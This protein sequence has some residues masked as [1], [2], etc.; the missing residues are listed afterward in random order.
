M[1]A[2]A[3]DLQQRLARAFAS[4]CTDLESERPVLHLAPGSGG[5]V[6]V[7]LEPERRLGDLDKELL[8]LFGSHLCLAFDNVSLCDRLQDANTRLEERVIQRTAELQRA[9]QRLAAQR[10]SLQRA[11]AFKNEILG[12]VAH[13][14][15][16][17]LGVI[18]G[19]AEILSDLLDMG[20]VP[21][22]PVRAQL[23]HIRDSAKRLTGMVDELM[24]QAI[25]DTLDISIRRAPL[26]FAALVAD[27][28][29]ANRP[30]ADRKQQS[31][32]CAGPANLPVNGDQERLREAIDNLVSNA[33]KYTPMG[34]VIE[35]AVSADAT[36][37]A[38]S[39]SDDGPG[40]A[41]EDLARVF[42]RFQ[43]LSAKPTGG[44]GST[45]LGLSIV[46]RIAELHGGRAS[47]QSLGPGLGATFTLRLP[48]EGAVSGGERTASLA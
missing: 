37:V 13:D 36:G 12:T 42:G 35:V 40:L 27:V 33:I 28:V 38:C 5:E 1:S 48:A 11:N 3:P 19:R 18:L 39:V 34:G 20:T 2:L 24:A 31:L 21:A 25:N 45:G 47:V 9:N 30:L 44:E 6:V 46:K 22:E 29:A 23:T 41:P 10:G 32:T 8:E 7:L 15:K 43:R 4:G 16:N 26:D 17:P 14:L